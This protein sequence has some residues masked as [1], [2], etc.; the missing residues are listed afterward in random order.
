M[1]CYLLWLL[2]S[3]TVRQ[4]EVVNNNYDVITRFGG[5]CGELNHDF[6]KLNP[7]PP[8]NNEAPNDQL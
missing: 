2:R 7:Q 8:G 3:T 6:V 5:S 1:V 4:D